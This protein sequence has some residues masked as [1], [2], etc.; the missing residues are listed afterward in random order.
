[1]PTV[2]IGDA[3]VVEG[4][5]GTQ[6]M[7][8]TVSLSAASSQNVRV[9]YKTVNGTARSGNKDFVATSGSVTFSPGQMSKT[10]T[11]AIKGD[12]KR[13]SD[14]RFYVNLSGASGATIAD[15]QGVGTILNDDFGTSALAAAV[16]QALE[17]LLTD[18]RKKGR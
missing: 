10:V 3:Q 14:E 16:D 12:T 7:T 9:N 11:V 8:F 5:S 13:E 15:G 18:R 1:L 4:N 17:G 2:S 6:L